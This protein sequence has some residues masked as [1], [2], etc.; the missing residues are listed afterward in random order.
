MK[1]KPEKQTFTCVRTYR[2]RGLVEKDKTIG[3]IITKWLIK[4]KPKQ[5][6][7]HFIQKVSTNQIDIHINLTS[8][9]RKT[10]ILRRTSL[11]QN[12]K[13][14]TEEEKNNVFR[15]LLFKLFSPIV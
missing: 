9:K 7:Q 5:K 6:K 3:Q 8:K 4:G 1:Q 14:K 15:F 13:L 10:K 12:K 11:K 2:D